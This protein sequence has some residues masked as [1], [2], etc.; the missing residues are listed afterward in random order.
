MIPEEESVVLPE[1]EAIKKAV[2]IP[3]I[4]LNLYDPETTRKAI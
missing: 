2:T 1:A 4:C 3:V